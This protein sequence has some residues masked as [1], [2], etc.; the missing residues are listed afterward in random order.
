M[1]PKPCPYCK[2]PI[3]LSGQ[4]DL[5]EDLSLACIYCGQLLRTVAAAPGESLGF[6]P[7]TIDEAGAAHHEVLGRLLVSHQ[8]KQVCPPWTAYAL[9]LLLGLRKH[10]HALEN[11]IDT[12]ALT[13][14]A[15]ALVDD[16]L[17]S[18]I[19]RVLL[20]SDIKLT[21]LNPTPTEDTH[22]NNA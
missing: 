15:K 17:P 7:F 16:R 11:A 14:A 2:K 21:G 5:K 8:R 18:A 6:R 20:A 10:L 4:L 19:D 22:D 12:A 3:D 13:D 9:S 1:K